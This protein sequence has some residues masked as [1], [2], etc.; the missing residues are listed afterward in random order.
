MKERLLSTIKMQ[1]AEY[2]E[3]EFDG[4]NRSG[5]VPFGDKVIVLPDKARDA[6]GSISLPAQVTERYTMAAITGVIVAMGEGAFAWNADKATQTVGRKPQVGDRVFMERY[7][8]QLLYGLDGNMYR[9]MDD[10][11]I[12]AIKEGSKQS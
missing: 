4:V 5:Y 2:V 1:D 11:C 12:G 9:V 10:R 7:G 6:I 3:Q 8:G